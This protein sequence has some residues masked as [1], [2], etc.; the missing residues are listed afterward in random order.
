MQRLVGEQGARAVES[1]LAAASRNHSGGILATV[2]GS[3]TL[4]LTAIGAFLELQT[5]LNAIWRVKPKPGFSIKD[6][7]MPRLRSF[8]LVVGIGFLLM[9]S[10]V[11][12]AGRGTAGLL[13]RGGPHRHP[14][15]VHRPFLRAVQVSP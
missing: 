7:L 10:L 15:R 13:G 6:F 5:A 1:L 11:V 2:I 4:I 14:G 3:L 8:G 12:S 9:V